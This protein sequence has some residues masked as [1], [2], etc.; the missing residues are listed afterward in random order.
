MDMF[1][2]IIIGGGAAGLAAAMYG[3]R[4]GLKTLLISVFLGGNM[5]FAH[6]VENYPGFE[7][8]KGMEL[9]EKLRA[10]AE[11]Y[12]V[13]FLEEKVGKVERLEK[14]FLVHAA[15]AIYEGRS[16]ILATGS[17]V[18]RLGVP[19]EREFEG[20]GVHYCAL[21]DGPVYKDKV[22]AVL[23]GSDAAVKESLLLSQ[24]AKKIYI[25]H[26]GDSMRCESCNYQELLS[27]PK[28]EVIA[29]TNVTEIMGDKL[30]NAVLLDSEYKGKRELHVDAVFVQ[31]GMVPASQLA[32]GLGVKLNEK[33]EVI[34]D[35]D[36]KT[37]VLGVFAAG[38]VTNSSSKQIITGAGEGV[39]AAY[40]AY[41]YLK[42]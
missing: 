11:K 17:E 42:T 15:G 23:G 21:C 18:R 5:N 28:I 2:I 24:Y 25:I 39:K 34:T 40:S 19:G 37:D 38:D 4:L 22:I 16:I 26:R 10:H 3:G 32:E 13:E 30:V 27:K 12:K 31:I 20:K 14:G 33:R 6:W 29:N 9:A 8:I 41:K 36:S 35:K 7:S 1:D